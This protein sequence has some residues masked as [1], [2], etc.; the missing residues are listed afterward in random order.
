M[1]CTNEERV[2]GPQLN[3]E[4]RRLEEART[5]EAPWRKW[6]PYLSAGQWGTVREDY[7]ESGDGQADRRLAAILNE[8][9]WTGIVAR[10]MHLFATSTAE[11]FLELGKVAG[12][13]EV[14]QPRSGQPASAA[15]SRGR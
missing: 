6:G 9:G 15:P 2:R 8:T 3:A 4:R 7:S 1:V 12:I 5:G 11:Q 14:E 13:V 10:V